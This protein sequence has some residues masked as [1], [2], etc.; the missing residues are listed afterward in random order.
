[1]LFVV[2]ALSFHGP[3]AVGHASRSAVS[4]AMMS[5][6]IPFVKA[7]P[8]LDGSMPGD[9]GFDPLGISTTIVELNGDLKYVREAE[10]V[11]GRVA[12]LAA[13]G[14]IFPE[15]FKFREYSSRALEAQAQVPVEV[16]SQIF[17][18]IAIAEGLRSQMIYKPDSVPGSHG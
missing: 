4:M 11:H 2:A 9:V 13:A 1:M 17:I 7:P 12:M 15:I 18:G 8:A 10:I 6:S 3:S 5:K 16:W 14:F